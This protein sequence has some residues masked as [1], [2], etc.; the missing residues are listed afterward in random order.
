MAGFFRGSDS[1]VISTTG[2]SAN[3]TAVGFSS[4]IVIWQ[5]LLEDAA[6]VHI[7]TRKNL[8]TL[9]PRCAASASRVWKEDSSMV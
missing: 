3:V 9:W 1:I 8:T 4:E 5:S 6:A 7:G 2:A